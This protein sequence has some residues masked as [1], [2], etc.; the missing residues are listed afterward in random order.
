MTRISVY[1]E[2]AKRL[3]EIAEAHDTTVA[4]VIS[5]ILD[6]IDDDELETILN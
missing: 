6:G 1:D 3:E 5:L 4:E 2:E